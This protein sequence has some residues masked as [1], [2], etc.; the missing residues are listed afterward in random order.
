MASCWDVHTFVVP[1]LG[2][3]LGFSAAVI[4]AILG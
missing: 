4:G 3:E 1:V 2:H